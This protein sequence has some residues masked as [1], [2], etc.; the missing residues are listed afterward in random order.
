LPEEFSKEDKLLLG[1]DAA[2]GVKTRMG[3]WAACLVQPDEIN[4]VVAVI[5]GSFLG[6]RSQE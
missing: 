2:H 4:Q 1:E 6:S 5:G 3:K